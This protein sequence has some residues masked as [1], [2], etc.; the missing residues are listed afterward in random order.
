MQN[1]KKKENVVLGELERRSGSSTS[2][3][4]WC[5]LQN[6]RFYLNRFCSEVNNL[7]S[8]QEWNIHTVQHASAKIYRVEHN[9][10][11]F[12][13]FYIMKALNGKL[14]VLGDF[15]SLHIYKTGKSLTKISLSEPTVLYI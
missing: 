6:V 15:F 4:S 12:S 14:T 5:E 10:L 2:K 3:T 11:P 7:P 1:S 9:I 13:P 8:Y